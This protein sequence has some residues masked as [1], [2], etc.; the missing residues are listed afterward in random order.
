M[1][2]N[3]KD[4]LT[5]KFRRIGSDIEKIFDD[6]AFAALSRRLTTEDRHNKKIS[7]AYPLLVNNY[8]AKAM[9]LAYEMGFDKVTEEVVMAI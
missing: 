6:Q 2:G 1:N 7:H 3:I 4:Y 5:L 9:N 8:A